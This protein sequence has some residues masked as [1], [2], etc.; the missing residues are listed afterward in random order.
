[1]NRF[2]TNNA[3]FSC[4]CLL[5]F[6]LSTGGCAEEEPA[7]PHAREVLKSILETVLIGSVAALIAYLVG[8]FF[9]H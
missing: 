2:M 1:M 3:I 4:V 7:E 8:T 5:A 6:L 9:S